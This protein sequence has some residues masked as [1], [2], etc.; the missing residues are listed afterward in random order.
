MYI[1]TPFVFYP[2]LASQRSQNETQQAN[3]ERISR[4]ETSSLRRN[5]NF[6]QA[7]EA[8]AKKNNA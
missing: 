7:V 8:S 6:K 5:A 4:N 3:D 1:Y 2:F